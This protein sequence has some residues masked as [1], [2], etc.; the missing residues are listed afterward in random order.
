MQAGKGRTA[1]KQRTRC[2]ILE[3]A[4]ELMRQGKP[5][6]VAAAAGLH[7][8][9]RATAYR[10][11]SDPAML[12][13]E[14]GLDIAVKPYE[15]IV[16]GAADL[17]Q[18]LRAISLYIFDLSTSHEARFRQFV[19]MTLAAW[20]P[21]DAARPQLRGARRVALYERALQEDGGGLAAAR[22][23]ALVRALSTATGTEAM[24]ALY[25]IVGADPAAA[26]ATVAE[27]ADAILDR[28]LGPGRT[29]RDGM[30]RDD[31]QGGR[32]EA[33]CDRAES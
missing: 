4:R 18:R 26:R 1:Q 9:S 14:A 17:R 27:I 5:V 13:A 21:E 10:Y 16:A 15:E 31:P 22:R 12:V 7:G 19:A 11:F 32:A 6:T 29:G 30:G 8:I 20:S 2:A 33:G 3:G 28:Y 23:Q 25:D 24:I